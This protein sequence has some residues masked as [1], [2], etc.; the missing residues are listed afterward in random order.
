MLDIKNFS[1]EF[2]APKLNPLNPDKGI[3]GD[4]IFSCCIA[5]NFVSL[6]RFGPIFVI[7]NSAL[8][9]IIIPIQ[10]KMLF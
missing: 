7:I 3:H 6:F 8:Q 5:I 2:N 9:K 10:M 4:K 1:F